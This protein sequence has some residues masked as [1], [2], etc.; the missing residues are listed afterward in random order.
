[1]ISTS[2]GSTAYSLSVG[3]PIV[4]PESKVLIISPIAPHNLNVRP[5]VVPDSSE[6]VLT[7]HSRDG[8]FEFS[9]DNSTFDVPESTR[10]VVKMAQF[11][12]KRVRLNKSNFIQAL[13][14]KLY[15]G[16]DVRNN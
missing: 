5:L 16:E 13:S 14:D 3:G 8:H 15:W 4:L 6:I 12:L 7:A 10:I 11:S 2:S 1:M 9:A